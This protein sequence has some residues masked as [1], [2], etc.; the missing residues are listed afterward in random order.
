MWLR[1]RSRR[2]TS[3]RATWLILIVVALA[4][5]CGDPQPPNDH[6]P[7]NRVDPHTHLW[8][9]GG[10]KH[11][12][13]Y[14]KVAEWKSADGVVT[15]V[16]GHYSGPIKRGEVYKLTNG[17]LITFDN[18]GLVVGGTQIPA[19]TSNVLIE[20]NGQVKLGPFIRTFD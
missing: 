15:I 12:W 5:G 3:M 10:N 11:V 7:A 8:L 13:T 2:R 4:T 20:E 9:D 16:D 14:Q 19:D 1:L 18:H 17:T 6:G